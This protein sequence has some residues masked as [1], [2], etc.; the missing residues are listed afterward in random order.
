MVSAAKTV[1]AIV[2]DEESVCTALSRLMRSAGF[3]SV[4]FSSGR[5]FIAW[6]KAS[7]PHCV[8]LDLHMPGIDCFEIQ[9]QL[10]TAQPGA[11]IPIIV[12]T[13]HDGTDTF[14]RAHERGVHA[15]LRKPVDD[16]L[17]LS[18][19]NAALAVSVP[20]ACGAT[21]GSQ[22]ADPIGNPESG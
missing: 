9:A 4:S 18:A 10:Q 7:R 14:T 12:I 22:R 1:I 3:D 21:E 13:G 5:Q 8:V 11:R 17:L 2:D 15:Y 20:P 6:A 19:I 16:V